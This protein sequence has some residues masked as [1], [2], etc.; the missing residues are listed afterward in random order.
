MIMKS[1]KTMMALALLT[2]AMTATSLAQ[3]PMQKKVF[4]T[5]NVP[6]E[7]RMGDYLLSSG[8]YTLYQVSQGDLNTFYLFRG[9]A[10]SHS[11]I[12]SIRTVMAG[13]PNRYPEKTEILWRYDDESGTPTTPVVTGWEIPGEGRW[14][15]ISVVSRHSHKE[16]TAALR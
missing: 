6:F 10:M 7:L 1:F 12:A 15:I 5:V 8:R 16:V 2:I 4:L 11:P 14:E 3:G 13:A 9:E